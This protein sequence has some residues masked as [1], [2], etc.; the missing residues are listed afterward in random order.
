MG[1]L[2]ANDSDPFGIFAGAGR[3]PPKVGV[4]N[5]VR[6]E[7][8]E[9]AAS[10]FASHRTLRAIL[11]RHEATI[12]KRWEKKTRTQRLAIL[13]QVW[14]GMAT[15]HR[16]DFAAFRKQSQLRFRRDADT[17][18]RDSYIWPIINQE[19]LGEPR[20]LSL[21]LNSRG[22]H[23]PNVFA[24]FDGELMHLGKVTMAVVPV[25]LNL[26]VML[27]NGVTKEDDYGKLLAWEDHEDAFTWMTSRKQ[28]LP[29]EGLL[30]LEFQDRLLKF[31]VDC[32]KSILHDIPSE[33]LTSDKFPICPEPIQKGSVDETGASTLAIMSKEAPY[34]PPAKLD[35]E[36]IES[37]LSARTVRAEDH[38]WSLREDPSYF[39]ETLLEIKD[40]LASPR[41]GNWRGEVS[42]ARVISNV[43]VDSFFQLESFTDLRDQ[44]T[45][46][47]HFEYMGALLRFR[48]YIHQ[49]MKRH[50]APR[51][52][53][54]KQDKIAYHLGW[55]LK[56][57]WEDGKDLFFCSM[58]VVID[59]LDRLLKVEPQALNLI[60]PYV[61]MLIGELSILGECLR[62]LDSFQPW[63]NGF[64]NALVDM[65]SDIK[66]E[67][68]E[69]TKPWAEV[70]NTFKEG[71]LKSIEQLGDP[72]GGRFDY[73]LGRR[74]NEANIGRL[75]QSEANL[76]V[77]WNAIDDLLYNKVRSLRGTTY[78]AI[79]SQPRYLQRTPEWVSPIDKKGS[80]AKDK[81]TS[82]DS[83]DLVLP[84]SQ[85]FLDA[86]AGSSTRAEI[87]AATAA[88]SGKVKVKSRGTGTPLQTDPTIIESSGS[89]SGSDRLPSSPGEGSQPD[90]QPRIEV[91]ARALKM[92]RAAFFDPAANTT[93]GEVAWRDFLH[94]MNAVGLAAQKLYGRSIQFHEPHPR[95]KIPFLTVRRHGR[96]LNRA[97]GWHGDMLVLKRSIPA[98]GALGK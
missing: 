14:P 90:T 20:T 6:H 65:E 8:K 43:L 91:D 47:R 37:L 93:P 62:Q 78:K 16:P 94:A 60:S 74:R 61:A 86:R 64:D 59:E 80:A 25:F 3:A 75:R 92:F 77:F 49:A 5:E 67:F 89:G 82:N 69:R 96:R 87:L 12:Q 18:Y 68:G 52:G 13:L 66:K 54:S 10:I 73:P 97:Y 19:D 35:F 46:L 24:A 85:L 95:G 76:D 29:G 40:I 81:K 7:A 33:D 63:A 36:R 48:H 1:H 2:L 56:T 15:T 50:L 79:L 22:R 26:H 27:L 70:I 42:W 32:C 21:L 71:N 53:A 83:Y 17:V 44:A 28:F 30:I 41:S 51:P 57:P 34:R 39:A 55:L 9:R 45:N 98:F 58:T 31:L 23:H 88:G 84:F 4:P 11:D 38:I 72:S